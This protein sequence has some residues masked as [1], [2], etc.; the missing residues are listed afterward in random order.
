MAFCH[1]AII[2]F[3]SNIETKVWHFVITVTTLGMAMCHNIRVRG[4][5]LANA[6]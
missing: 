2:I 4:K 1:F 5:P 6:V 3:I